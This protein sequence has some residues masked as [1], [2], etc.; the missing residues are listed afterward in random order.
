MRYD[1]MV[2][3]II[4]VHNRPYLLRDAVNSVLRQSWR[5]IEIV[6]IDDGSTDETPEMI[7]KLEGAHPEIRS[8]RLE[9]SGPGRA[10]EAGRRAAR[11]EF[12]QY[13]DSDDL[14]APRKFE[15]QL[16]GL[17][18][19]PEYDV[20]YGKTSFGP[21]GTTVDVKPWKRTGERIETMFPSFLEARWWG[22]STP[23]YRRAVADSVGPWLNTKAEEDWEYDCRIA[24]KGGRLYF[25]DD[26]VSHERDHEGDRL[27]RGGSSDPQKLKDRALARCLVYQHGKAYGVSE[28]SPELIL[29]SRSTFLLA[30][31]CGAAGLTEQARTLFELARL[32]AGPRR[33]RGLDFIAYQIGAGIFGWNV[34]GKISEQIDGYRW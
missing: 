24:R 6:I 14:L 4:P 17:L 5:P 18:G 32:A 3:T 21:V 30:R 11:G 31:Q 13:L 2:T 25:V 26:F 20:A 29:F 7:S 34:A 33:R 10:R 23:L 12:I 8:F 1:G 19:Q 9:N 22:T 28:E 16:A 27:S 15:L